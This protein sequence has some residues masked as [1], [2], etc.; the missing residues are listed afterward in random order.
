MVR[1]RTTSSFPPFSKFAATITI[2]AKIIIL[3]SH[4]TTNVLE[5]IQRNGTN[6]F[7]IGRV[8]HPI[9]F[10]FCHIF[11]VIVVVIF[12]RRH[13]YVVVVA[14]DDVT[15]FVAIAA[16]ALFVVVAA[17]VVVVVVVAVVVVN[18]V[19]QNQVVSYYLVEFTN[20]C[21]FQKNVNNERLQVPDLGR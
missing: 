19:Q 20:F 15:V 9:V 4:H 6:T 16:V 13:F 2:T 17:V 12:I 11:I 18:V 10:D 7:G 14:D 21:M 8:R 3:V 5:S 1:S